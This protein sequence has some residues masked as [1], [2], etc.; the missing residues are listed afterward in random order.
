METVVP[1]TYLGVEYFASIDMHLRIGLAMKSLPLICL[2]CLASSH[3]LLVAQD[4]KL[5]ALRESLLFH[6]SFDKSE[7]ADFARGDHRLYTAET[8]ER[9]KVKAGLASDAVRLDDRGKFNGS[10]FFSKK[11][12]KI[13]FYK[14]GENVVYRSDRSYGTTISFWMSLTPDSDLPPDFVDPL[15]M[16]DKKWNDAAIFVDFN[17]EAP[18]QFRLGVYSNFK[19]W[20]P[21]NRKY[22]DIPESE[23]PLVSVHQPPFRNDKWTHVAITLRGVN[24]GAGKNG[25]AT[26]YL[27]GESQGSLDRPLRFSWDV[28]QVAVVLGIHYVGHIDDFAMFDRAFSSAEVQQ[29]RE[30]P[31]GI[32]TITR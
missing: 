26:L 5:A 24:A 7:H 2:I 21:N 8:L 6:A 18:R 11:T 13:T 32:K 28:D 12:Q 27:D 20:N 15:Q 16:T 22:N 17:K 1:Q 3:S 19:F 30:L 4:A 10:L 29:L 31:K 14:G 25:S 9:E 23:L